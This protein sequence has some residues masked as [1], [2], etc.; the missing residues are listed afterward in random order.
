VLA[1]VVLAG[2]FALSGVW[3]VIGLIVLMHRGGGRP[4]RGRRGGAPA[5]ATRGAWW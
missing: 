2:L 5:R 3:V 4:N 1:A